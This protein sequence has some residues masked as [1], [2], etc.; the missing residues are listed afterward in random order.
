MSG[1]PPLVI[2]PFDSFSVD[3]D[4]LVRLLY[5]ETVMINLAPLAARVQ[6]AENQT[7]VGCMLEDDIP[8]D[9]EKFGLAEI[10]QPALFR[11]HRDGLENP[12]ALVL[13]P[14]PVSVPFGSKNYREEQVRVLG[15]AFRALVTAISRV[16]PGGALSFGILPAYLDPMEDEED[17][18]L[19]LI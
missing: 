19:V 9:D 11:L 18:E 4:N 12:T 7:T 5:K 14:L 17:D 16:W 10:L 8:E 13:Y 2:E 1:P 3:S 6:L 15:V